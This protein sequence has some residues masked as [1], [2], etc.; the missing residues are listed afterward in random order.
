MQKFCKFGLLRF[1]L[2]IILS[3]NISNYL[4]DTIIPH[5][6]SILWH[7]LLIFKKNG[8][9]I[10]VLQLHPVCN[11]RFGHYYAYIKPLSNM[12]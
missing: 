8:S 11:N 6:L 7:R 2:A 1:N 10:I 5:S 12:Q 3:E 9:I 4:Y